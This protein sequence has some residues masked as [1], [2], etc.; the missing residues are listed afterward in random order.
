MIS[1]TVDNAFVQ[2]LL[3]TD[4]IKLMNFRQAEAYTRR[5]PA[6]SQVVLPKGILDLSKNKPATDIHL[7]ATTTNLIVRKNLH[8]A[9][10]IYSWMLPWIFMAT[11]A[12]SIR[13][14]NSPH[15][16]HRTFP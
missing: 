14:A 16:N 7:L 13:Q 10:I 15:P 3:Y 8:P 11:R 6:L 9:M 12:G 1:S 5:F 2:E 4:G